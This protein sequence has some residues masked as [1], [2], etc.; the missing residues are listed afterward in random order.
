MFN[1]NIINKFIYIFEIL[2]DYLSINIYQSIIFLIIDKLKFFKKREGR[3]KKNDI[4]L[5]ELNIF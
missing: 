2:I 4:K 1:K 5:Y 3:E